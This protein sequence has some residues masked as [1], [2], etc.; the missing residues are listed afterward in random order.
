MRHIVVLA[1]IL[2]LAGCGGGGGGGG[3]SAPPAPPAT[4]RDYGLLVG[5]S[6]GLYGTLD[7]S[8]D[9]IGFAVRANVWEIGSAVQPVIP[10]SPTVDLEVYVD[11]VLAYTESTTLPMG[12]AVPV[13]LTLEDL[14]VTSLYASDIAVVATIA[15][16]PGFPD[17]VAGNNAASYTAHL[18][19]LIAGTVSA[20]ATGRPETH[21]VTKGA[22]TTEDFAFTVAI[23][24]TL[25]SGAGPATINLSL[26]AVAPGVFS[27][28]EPAVVVASGQMRY[29]LDG[30]VYADGSV[31]YQ[32]TV[33]S[34]LSSPG[35]VWVTNYTATW[36]GVPGAGG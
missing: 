14:G 15:A 26:D 18:K 9:T 24:G 16:E 21:T 23:A 4:Q 35:A 12:V 25:G 11:G 7:Y 1:L 32:I 8:A 13:L 10:T 29:Q 36:V 5:R 33:E 22:P 34:K 6:A 3:S 19:P 2:V 31:T 27:Y 20:T 28:D 30:E 17:P